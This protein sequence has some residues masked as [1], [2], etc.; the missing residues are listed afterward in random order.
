M[1]TT[2]TLLDK[3]TLGSTQTSVEFTGLGAYSSNYTDLLVKVSA[4]SARTNDA[5]GSDGKLEFNGATTGFSSRGLF[6]QGSAGSA[7]PSSI[8]F[9]VDS[10]NSTSNTYGNMEV[11]IPNFSSSNYKSVSLD[12]VSENNSSTA[13]GVLIAG[14]WANTAA[15]TSMKFTDNNGGFLATSSFYLY[16]IKKN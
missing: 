14:L 15:I 9:F 3:T 7:S 12:A 10:N 1:A 16:G 11:Y 8:F 2:Y 5:G 13:Y 6:Q 4:R